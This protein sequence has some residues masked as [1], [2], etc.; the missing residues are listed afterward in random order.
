MA[1]REHLDRDRRRDRDERRRRL[2]HQRLGMS[3]AG[4]HGAPR[5]RE[6]LAGLGIEQGLEVGSDHLGSGEAEQPAGPEAG[7]DAVTVVVDDDQR[8]R[9]GGHAA[10]SGSVP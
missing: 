7:L 5:L 2:E 9:A 1:R 8:P 10:A 6:P 4:V 3:V